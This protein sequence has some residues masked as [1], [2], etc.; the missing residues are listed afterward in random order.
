MRPPRI[1]PAVAALA[2]VLGVAGCQRQAPDP[3]D[4]IATADGA[5]AR[6]A[7]GGGAPAG[8]P[9]AVD[10]AG[11]VKCLRDRGLQVTYP[12]PDIGSKPQLDE[13]SVPQD[14]L[15]AALQACQRFNPNYGVKAPPMDP[16]TLERWRQFARC[17]RAQGVDWPDPEP[18]D[19][20]PRFPEGP[21][22]PGSRDPGVARDQAQQDQT[23]AAMETCSDQVPGLV[24]QSNDAPPGG[25]KP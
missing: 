12:D 15:R 6:G 23:T 2:L 1:A 4:G 25:K 22:D 14:K 16:A 13:S 11:W 8:S 17:M 5:A 10:E 19:A 24:T 7:A 9:P 18:G 20:R 21:D 3:A